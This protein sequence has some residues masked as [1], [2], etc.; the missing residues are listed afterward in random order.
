MRVLLFLFLFALSTF[1]QVQAKEPTIVD[2]A[3]N[4]QRGGYVLFMRHPQTNPDQADVDPLHLENVA[5]QRQLTDEGRRTARQIGEA[6]R[7]LEIPVA[8]VISSKFFRAQEAAKLLGMGEVTPELDVS[9]GGLVV[10]PNENKR[11]AD[12]LKKLLSTPPKAGGNLLIVS[13][14]P[15]L[16]DAA[17][18]EFGD[19]G[20]GEIVIFQPADDA[21]LHLIARVPASD[22]PT[23][24]E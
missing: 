19:L 23:A 2:L 1:A 24:A 6:L 15:N 3:P 12:A 17:G 18:K 20:E 5:A 4:L 8:Q 11:R 21:E 13:H 16:Q 9:E 22:W 10:S 14:K 7:R